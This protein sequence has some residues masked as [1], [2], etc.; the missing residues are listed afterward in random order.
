[1]PPSTK[2]NTIPIAFECYEDETDDQIADVATIKKTEKHPCSPIDTANRCETFD[3]L[4]ADIE[5]DMLNLE[6]Q[7]VVLSE[8][9]PYGDVIDPAESEAEALA[10]LGV[11]EWD[12]YPP[13]DPASRIGDDFNYVLR[14]EDFAEEGDVKLEETRHRTVIADIDEVKM[15][16]AER[17]ELFSMLADDLDSYDLLAEEANLPL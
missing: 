13:I 5:D 15:S 16:K 2:K 8:D 17:N 3:S 11:E 9:R 4:A 1:M 10:E 12:S 7:D 14:T 6:D